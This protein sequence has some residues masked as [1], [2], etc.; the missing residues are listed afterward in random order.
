[1]DHATSFDGLVVANGGDVSD[2]DDVDDADLSVAGEE[3]PGA[4]LD[5]IG[6]RT[7]EPGAR[8]CPWPR[9]VLA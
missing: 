2:S 6:P 3:D 1:M 8:W 9:E 4:A 7:D 5:V